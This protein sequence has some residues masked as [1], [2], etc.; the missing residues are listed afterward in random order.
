MKFNWSWMNLPVTKTSLSRKMLHLL[1]VLLGEIYKYFG[2]WKEHRTDIM[3]ENGL[4]ITSLYRVSQ[5]FQ[6]DTIKWIACTTKKWCIGGVI[7]DI[8]IYLSHTVVSLT[9]M[10]N[11]QPSHPLL[12]PIHNPFSQW[13]SHPPYFDTVNFLLSR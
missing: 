11:F 7:A 5:F 10:P 6:H 3:Y 8:S 2:T 1:S 13:H 4:W 12:L 9:N